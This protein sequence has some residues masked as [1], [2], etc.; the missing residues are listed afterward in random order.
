MY[1]N[2]V[3]SGFWYNVDEPESF[4]FAKGQVRPFNLSTPDGEVLY[5][6]HI[7]P[8]NIYAQH[9]PDLGSAD[10]TINSRTLLEN[11]PNARVIVNCTFHPASKA[12]TTSDRTP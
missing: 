9:E 8:I 5:G 4:G 6:W 2:K 10:P 1:A 12:S 3:H 7:L 11:D